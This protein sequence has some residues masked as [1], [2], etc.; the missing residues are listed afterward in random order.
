MPDIEC[1]QVLSNPEF[2][3]EGTAV[4]DLTAPDRVLIGGLQTPEGLSAIEALAS[5]YRHWVPDERII[6]GGR[7]PSHKGI[8]SLQ[9]YHFR[10]KGFRVCGLGHTFPSRVPF[11]GY[12]LTL[13]ALLL[14]L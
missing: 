2:L 6:T 4:Q 11:P 5:V 14:T 10:V 9:V 8:L 7:P 12:V 13:H 3:A 1:A